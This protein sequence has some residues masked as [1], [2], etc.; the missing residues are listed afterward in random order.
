MDQIYGPNDVVFTGNRKL[1][2]E[3]MEYLKELRENLVGVFGQPLNQTSKKSPA[4][5][6][7]EEMNM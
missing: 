7:I 2:K 5:I 1:T 3:D 6:L 4:K